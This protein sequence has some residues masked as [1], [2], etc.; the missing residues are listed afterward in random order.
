ME[1]PPSPNQPNEDPALRD[2]FRFIASEPVLSVWCHELNQDLTSP[3]IPYTKL[4]SYF[5]KNLKGILKAL[6]PDDDP[7][8]APDVNSICKDFSKTFAILLHIDRGRDISWFL[9]K[10]D[11]LTDSHL[12]YESRPRHWPSS[13]DDN[14]FNRFLEKQWLFCAVQF[15]RNRDIDF[16]D[17]RILPITSKEVLGEGGSAIVHKARIYEEYNLL[18]G[19]HGDVYHENSVICHSLTATNKLPR[20]DVVVVKSYVTSDA[21]KYYKNELQAYRRLHP[22]KN[23]SRNLLGFYSAFQHQGHYNIIVEH[24]N[25]GTLEEILHN[26]DPPSKC[27][28]RLKLWDGL[29][30]VATGLIT[31][32]GSHKSADEDS[33][34]MA[35]SVG[36]FDGQCCNCSNFPFQLAPRPEAIK[37]LRFP[38]QYKL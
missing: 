11:A 9:T 6:L 34:F 22:G 18:S 8:K 27:E 32:H 29:L 30:K 26:M 28:D 33:Y 21:Q 17:R 36:F 5:E 16:H 1:T 35:G 12:P 10:G 23:W 19:D 2:F 3:F 13:Q 38:R 14:D 4:F 37:H 7:G 31:I 24:A 25:K 20:P 15:D